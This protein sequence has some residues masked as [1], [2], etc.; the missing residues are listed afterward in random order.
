VGYS[1]LPLALPC[2]LLL[3]IEIA[4]LGG[5]S[6]D[7]N[8]SPLSGEAAQRRRVAILALLA[9][10]LPRPI[11]R[12]R[13]IGCLWPDND[14]ESARHLLSSAL[15]VL[16]RG[17]GTDAVNASSGDVALSAAE[18]RSDVAEFRRAMAAGDVEGAVA[19][20]AGDFMDGFFVND[21]PDF[22]QW[23]DGERAELR[24]LC[25]TGLEQAAKLRADS[26]DGA[27]AAEAWR[28]RAALDPYDSQVA[29]S[30][31]HALAAANQRAAAIQHARIHALLLEQE[32]GAPV[33]PEIEALAASLRETPAE[34]TAKREPVGPPPAGAPVADSSAG[35]AVA[36]GPV[37]ASSTESALVRI[38]GNTVAADVRPVP[39]AARLTRHWRA[40][41]L[42]L[43]IPTVFGLCLYLLLRSLAGPP[44]LLIA[45]RPFEAADTS[46]VD[47]AV[48]AAEDLGAQM[49]RLEHVRVVAH[50]LAF[51]TAGMA[52]Q[53]ANRALGTDAVFD[54]KLHWHGQRLAGVPE[55][56]D[57][58][59]A[60]L[61]GGEVEAANPTELTEN[62]LGLLAEQ[63]GRELAPR[64]QS[65]MPPLAAVPSSA[66]PTS[67]VDTDTA[68][69]DASHHN[70]LGLVAWFQ[71]TRA[72]LR[73]ALQHFDT[74]I[75]IDSSYARA[76]LGRANALALLGSYDY[77]GMDPRR[78]FP[79][80]D[81][82]ARRALALD[83]S[84]T[85][86]YATL[87]LVEMNYRWNWEEAEADF[88]RALEGRPD[89]APARE[90]YALLL[91]ARR[92]PDDA[93]RL[94]NS[95]VEADPTRPTPLVQRAHV[96]YYTGHYA[97]ARKDLDEALS[98]DNTFVRARFLGTVIDLA[99]GDEQL[100]L[101]TLRAFRAMSTDPEPLLIALLGYAHARTG[102]TIAARA[103]LDSLAQIERS[104]Y[105]PPELLALVH[106]A[107][108]ENDAAFD[109]LERAYRIN[110]GGLVYLQVEPL[111]EPI[112]S[113][114]RFRDLVERVHGRS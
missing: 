74:A 65:P 17:L 79:A 70:A 114:P 96:S 98:R 77:A 95:A 41:W 57:T 3:M 62:L 9:A 90:W 15:Y 111:I 2:A 80:A 97:E 8:G 89:Y 63:L 85:A 86:A 49:S 73:L 51:S 99:T 42:W 29:L 45:V 33:A 102:D 101:Q 81:A 7:V 37:A 54:M 12:D 71:R 67:L 69:T 5:V 93:R 105:V 18:V 92:R 39:A 75:A 53:M 4:L 91:A 84:L 87:G 60:N 104:Q 82:A 106:V 14:E 21:A 16:R 24:R 59:N 20:Y 46:L 13:L 108:G 61:V 72:S 25:G 52:P 27:G 78:A 56:L 55:L 38:P 30:L 58:L 47:M 31:M 22:M 44:E 76:W 88:K 110:S 83:S 36:P 32:F 43:A 48:L 109:Q 107:L 34:N 100:A 19:L 1:R 68:N 23:V 50:T 28:R 66:A 6:V 112:R 35:S 26:G 64:P 113:D 10:A 103:Q 40:R 94:A 11:S